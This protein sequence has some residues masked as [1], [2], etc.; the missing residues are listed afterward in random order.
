MKSIIRTLLV[1]LPLLALACDVGERDAAQAPARSAASV[2]LDLD[3]EAELEQHDDADLVCEA[4][5]EL[6]A[7]SDEDP[8]L[9][10]LQ[11]CAV[12]T[13][14]ASELELLDPTTEVPT[15][16]W[17][18]TKYVETY[19]AC[20]PNPSCKIGNTPCCRL[21]LKYVRTC[22]SQGCDEWVYV[23]SQCGCG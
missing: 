8:A 22:T 18:E 14:A 20:G 17:Q 19:V 13:D 3:I 4:W 16:I 15:I 11:P 23:G 6:G 7:L 5:P 10:D 9:A 21:A 12:W 1:T 2:Q